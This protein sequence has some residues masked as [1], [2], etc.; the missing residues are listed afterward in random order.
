MAMSK[1]CTYPLFPS[2]AFVSRIVETVS[3]VLFLGRLPLLYF[4]SFAT[5]LLLCVLLAI[6]WS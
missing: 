2:I 5:T 6:D 3:G 4:F 1:F